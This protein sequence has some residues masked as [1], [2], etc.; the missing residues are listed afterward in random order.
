MISFARFPLNPRTMSMLFYH[1]KIC[2]VVFL[3]IENGSASGNAT[4]TTTAAPTG[5][6]VVTQAP[7]VNQSSQVV[8]DF[9]GNN[10]TVTNSTE[11]HHR[12][13]N[14]YNIFISNTCL[15]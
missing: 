8:Q 11:D 5:T 10:V 9:D 3:E 1:F 4:V 7:P 14:R 13:Y 12:Y 6:P 15:F 2:N